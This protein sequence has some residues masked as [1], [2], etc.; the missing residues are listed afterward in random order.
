[1][2]RVAGRTF[3]CAFSTR[4]TVATETPAC[5]ATP[6]IESPSAER[7]ARESGGGRGSS[8]VADTAAGFAFDVDLDKAAASENV[9]DYIF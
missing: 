8:P 3:S 5:L 4:D 2:S 6:A 7:D 9:I 1:L